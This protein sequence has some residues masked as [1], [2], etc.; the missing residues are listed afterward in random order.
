MP[1]YKDSAFCLVQAA[2]SDANFGQIYTTIVRFDTISKWIGPQK[3]LFEGDA[4][5]VEGSDLF[6]LLFQSG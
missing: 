5:I 4:G 6:K 1:Y 3:N 2:M